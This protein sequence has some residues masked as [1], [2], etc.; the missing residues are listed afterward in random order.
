MDTVVV[1]MSTY[2]GERFLREQID[3]IITQKDVNIKLVVRDDG[4]TDDT[5]SILEKYQNDGKLSLIRGDNIGPNRSF[6]ELL[7]SVFEAPYYAFA[8]QDDVWDSD[9]IS[10]ALNYLKQSR[11]AAMYHCIAGVVDEQLN[12]I[13]TRYVEPVQTF[14]GSLL[15]SATGCTIVFNKCL[16]DYLRIY[17]PDCNKV[18][19]HDVWVYRVAYAVQADVYYDN[20]SHMKYRQH[21]F[22]YTGGV[23]SFNEKL[24]RMLITRTNTR[25]LTCQ[26]VIRG[27]SKYMNSHDLREGKKLA[28]YKTSLMARIRLFLDREIRTNYLKTN[29]QIKV[30]ILLGKL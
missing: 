14:A 11:K 9:K 12:P 4:S 15:T 25:S 10:I 26:E 24:K 19:M 1:L 28:E 30:L 13:D 6:V 23:N 16:L 3:S 17:K 5:L 7:Y 21:R 2:N 22:N 8:D 29:I 20:C 27:F 18:S